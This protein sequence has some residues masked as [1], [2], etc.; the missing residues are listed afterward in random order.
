[1]EEKYMALFAQVYG[2]DKDDLDIDL[3]IL[4]LFNVIN[5]NERRTKL[6]QCLKNAPS[7]TDEL[8]TQL[9]QE[10]TAIHEQLISDK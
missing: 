10:M 3:D 4:Q 1:L 8:I 9:L 7:S 5:D 6:E 2:V